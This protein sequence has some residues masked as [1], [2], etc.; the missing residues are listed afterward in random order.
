MV[1][2]DKTRQKV[3]LPS[4]VVTSNPDRQ[5]TEKYYRN[6]MIGSHLKKYSRI[7]VLEEDNLTLTDC[8]TGEDMA[9]GIPG[10]GMVGSILYVSD[11]G[12]VSSWGNRSY[13]LPGYQLH[14]E[15]G[16]P[17]SCHNGG[18]CAEHET[19]SACQNACHAVTGEAI[20]VE[21]QKINIDN[22]QENLVTGRQSVIPPLQVLGLC[23]TPA[24][25][26]ST[27]A[28]MEC[29]IIWRGGIS[30]YVLKTVLRQVSLSY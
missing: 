2:Q 15:R 18:R 25:A 26:P 24:L 8:E 22:L 30:Q 16:G 14:Q 6:I 11:P 29:A 10:V 3:K 21:Y 19:E 12:L 17:Q 9:G 13:C 7:G 5:T 28:M 1:F 4:E 27:A 20:V 23:T